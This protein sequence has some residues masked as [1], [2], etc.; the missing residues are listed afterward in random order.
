M[1][2]H[3]HFITNVIKILF[4]QSITISITFNIHKIFK[5]P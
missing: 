5:N 2:Y 1:I 3:Q 4:Q